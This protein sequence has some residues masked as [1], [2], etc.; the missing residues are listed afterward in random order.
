MSQEEEE[1][2]RHSKKIEVLW[3]RG[4]DEGRKTTE[5]SF[6]WTSTRKKDKGTSKEEV[7]GQH[8]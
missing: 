6:V 7:A 3:S 1:E 5:H 2:D 4:E 8:S